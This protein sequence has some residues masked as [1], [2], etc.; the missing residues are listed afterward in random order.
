MRVLTWN[1]R[2][3]R[4]DAAGVARVIRAAAPDIALIQEAPRLW[5]WR[6]KCARLARESGLVVVTGGRPAAGNLL[7]CSMRVR[8]VSAYDILL[9]KRPGLHRRG[10]VAAMLELE[11][12]QVS[13]LGT[14]LD[15]DATA[16]LG[17][18][19][20]L[21]EAAYDVVGADVN[22]EPGGPAWSALSRGLED[23]AAGLGPTFSVANLRRRIDALFVV[24]SWRARSC[25]VLDAGPVSDHLPIV[26]ELVRCD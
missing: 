11:G 13:V 24:P 8:V 16:R 10:A 12:Q 23:I 17:N 21:R 6:S 9:P 7:L 4:D 26:A 1:V 5:R 19:L 14:H 22:E 25:Q 20:R 18:A 3:L 2:S 15:L